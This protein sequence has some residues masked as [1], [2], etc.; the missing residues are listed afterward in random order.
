[1]PLSRAALP[2][3]V[4]AWLS[5]IAAPTHAQS[6]DPSG[7]SA[8]AQTAASDVDRSL[9]SKAEQAHFIFQGVVTGVEYRLS[10]P[11]PEGAPQLPYTFVTYRI[12]ELL[13]GEP[14]GQSSVTLRFLGGPRDSDRIFQVAG[15]PFFDVGDRD[16]LFVRR[17]GESI[18]PLLD[19]E[20]GRFRLI[21]DRVFNDLGRPQSLAP[22]G[23]LVSGKQEPLR[24]VLVNRVG[25]HIV[26]YEMSAGREEP[27]DDSASKAAPATPALPALDP[28]QFAARVR[29]EVQKLA[30]AGRLQNHP[31]TSADIK[32]PLVAPLAKAVSPPPDAAAGQPSVAE[33]QEQEGDRRRQPPA[34]F[35]QK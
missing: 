21:D 9:P 1:M 30:Q 4:G 28:A 22:T 17:N 23:E 27:P 16:I 26:E 34:V 25:G 14:Q 19:C 2:A 20:N 10:D 13:K 15:T 31:V 12:D 29:Q 24:E 5:G 8:T 33:R 11:S 3:L 32:A 7:S 35:V 18:C 6:Q